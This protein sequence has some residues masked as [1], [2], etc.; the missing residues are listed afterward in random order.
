MHVYS[1]TVLQIDLLSVSRNYAY[2]LRFWV[3]E[4]QQGFGSKKDYS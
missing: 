2:T 3:S 4:K 1:I